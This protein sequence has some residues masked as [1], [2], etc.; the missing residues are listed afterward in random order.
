MGLFQEITSAIQKANLIPLPQSDKAS[1]PYSQLIRPSNDNQALL[2][3]ESTEDYQGLYSLSSSVY[4]AV[5]VI[6]SNIAQLPIKVVSDANPNE[7]LVDNPDFSLFKTYNQFH[8][9]YEFW[10]QSIGYLEL[11]GE[12]PWLLKRDNLGKIIEI[13]CKNYKQNKAKYIIIP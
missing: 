6:S 3:N 10:E 2:P 8:T 7:N 4:K 5:G 9:P 13:Y 1:P 12:C 11:T